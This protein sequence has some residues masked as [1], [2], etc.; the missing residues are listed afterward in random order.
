[1]KLKLQIR[2]LTQSI[3]NFFVWHFY[4][5]HTKKWKQQLR[6]ASE[7]AYQRRKELIGK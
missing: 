5:K 6:Q 7:R 3:R 2:F 4:Y 1:M